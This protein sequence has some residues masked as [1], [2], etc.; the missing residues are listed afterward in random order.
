MAHSIRIIPVMHADVAVLRALSVKTFR[1][2]YAAA[3]MP[4]NIEAY[5]ENSFSLSALRAE[6]ADP[7]SQFFFAVISGEVAGY[8]KVNTGAAQT[9]QDL[10]DAM[11]LERIYAARDHQGKGVG[12]A[13]IRHA[14]SLAQSANMPWLWLGVWEDNPRAIEFYKRQN[15]EV[16]GVHNFMMGDDPQRDLMM[17]IKTN[18]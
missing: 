15:L 18:S 12:K 13:M 2:T 11:E 1:D 4:E 7:N 16:F 8:L 14:I 10:P 3:N 17:R 9:E 6:L 5:I